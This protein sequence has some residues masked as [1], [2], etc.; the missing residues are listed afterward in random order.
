[1]NFDEEEIKNQFR[2]YVE[3][4]LLEGGELMPVDDW[5]DGAIERAV[6][7]RATKPARVTA[8]TPALGTLLAFLRDVEN[9]TSLA[10]AQ[11]KARETRAA[12]SHRERAE[13]KRKD[14]LVEDRVLGRVIDTLIDTSIQQGES[15]DG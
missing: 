14:V 8:P 9:A 5:F 10:D 13:L 1:M 4:V 12:L 6:H 15:E 11:E 2:W 7:E 3:R